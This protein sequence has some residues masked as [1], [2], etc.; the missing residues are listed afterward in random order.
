M[1]VFIHSKKLSWKVVILLHTEP[2]GPYSSSE[3]VL[4]KSTGLEC[5]SSRILFLTSEGL[6][7]NIYLKLMLRVWLYECK[8][9][10]ECL[11]ILLRI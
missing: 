10:E 1:A 11:Q 2:I 5:K 3:T 7:N 6:S 9:W 8:M 4:S